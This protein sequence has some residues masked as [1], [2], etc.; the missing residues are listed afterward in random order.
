MSFDENSV[1]FVDDSN[2]NDLNYTNRRGGIDERGF[3]LGELEPEVVD[4][5][6]AG[7][8]APG[9]ERVGGQ[10]GFEPVGEGLWVGEV[11]RLGFGGLGRE[12][13]GGNL[14]KATRV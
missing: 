14:E 4:V 13:H 6:G 5:L 8:D 3:A 2:G 10:S 9:G 1:G 12:G 11:V 7:F